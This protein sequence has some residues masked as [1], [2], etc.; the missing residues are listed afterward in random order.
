MR[1]SLSI[2]LIVFFLLVPAS[3]RDKKVIFDGQAAW[4]Y[5]RDLAAD[6]MEGRRSGQP[7]AVRAEEYIA[8]RFKEWGLEP[9]GDDGTWFQNFTIEHRH[10]EEGVVFE[11]I[12][13]K[14]RRDFY[15]GEDW[16]VQGY[17][18]SARAAAEIVFVGYGIHAP[19]KEYD[20]YAGVDVRGKFIL[21]TTDTPKKLAK[22]LEEEAR[23]ESRIRAAQEH[24][25]LGI[26]AF[27]PSSITGRYSGMAARKE[28]YKPDFVI[29][30]IEDKI[31]NFIFKELPTDTR[32]LFQKIEREAKPQSFATGVKAFVSVNS[33][34]DEKRPTR[35][36]LAKIT[37]SDSKLKEETIVIGAHMDHLGVGPM[38]DIYNGA[39]DNASGTAVVM[40]LAR[41]MKLSRARPGRTVIFALWAGEEQG[42]LGSRYYVDNPTSPIE[43]TVANINLDMVGI[44]SGK[45][46]YGGVYYGPQIWKLWEEKLPERLLEPIRPSRGG[47]GGSDHTP[48]LMKGIPAFFAIAE[49]SFLKYHQPR[50]EADL[51]QPELLKS[52]GDFLYAA[53]EVLASEPADFILPMREEHFQFKYQNLVNFRFQPLGHVIETHAEAKDSHV[54]LQMAVIEEKEGLSGDTLR[55]DIVNSLFDVPEKLKKTKLALYSSPGSVSANT[56]LGKTTV[57]P[58]LKGTNA[59]RDNPRWAKVLAGQGAYFVVMDEPASLFGEQGLGE[60]GKTFVEE[61]SSSELLVFVRGADSAQTRV[62]LEESKKPMVFFQSELPDKEILDLIKNKEAALGL[63]MGKD[64]DPAAYF[65][66]LQQ[67][68]EAI[69][70]QHLMI[71]NEQ[72]LWGA[73]A[74]DQMLKLIS[75]MIKEK[76][77][78]TDFSNLFSATLL[79]VM[80]AV[81]P[82]GPAGP[83][84]YIPF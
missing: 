35:N 22:K 77:E 81:R 84:P 51:I 36:V 68:R 58:G 46:N 56:R 75:E 42:L 27:R 64:E 74:Q 28:L 79:R 24:G 11:I 62:L 78:R 49:E 20:E 61:L 55:V 39:N 54:D 37:G 21:V 43:K 69:G 66:K 34:F 57:V 73:K 15:Y 14:G 30:S 18:G 2:L 38:S 32:L 13:E 50:D 41:V 63:V 9:A 17:S 10:I 3:A 5:V 52:I 45:F 26:I 4:S 65:Q 8:S 16:R 76:Y 53:V 44:G 7:G 80:R 19:E 23:M 67:A 12:T 33:I 70:T 72:C 48:F 29:L 1:K 31:L 47:P 6:E 83:V 25:A 71:V 59:L 82:E 60:E 40:E